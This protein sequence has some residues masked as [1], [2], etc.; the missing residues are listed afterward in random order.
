MLLGLRLALLPQVVV[1]HLQRLVQ[2]E[3]LGV[4]GGDG[5][6]VGEC[7]RP[8]LLPGR[9]PVGVLVELLQLGKVE[10]GLNAQVVAQRDFLGGSDGIGKVR[11][12][13]LAVGAVHVQ[14]WNVL[15]NAFILLQILLVLGIE[16]VPFD[17]QVGVLF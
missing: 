10:V 5:L 13:Q 6:A 7:S 9:Y 8:L 16:A 12:P 15:L 2:S 4:V 14:P 3:H 11:I 1:V 17:R